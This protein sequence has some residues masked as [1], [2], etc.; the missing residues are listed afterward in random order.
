VQ[1][2]DSG[3]CFKSVR[4]AVQ[5]S[6][7]NEQSQHGN[8]WASSGSKYCNSWNLWQ[9]VLFSKYLHMVVTL[10]IPGIGQYT[11]ERCFR[12]L[13][14][15]NWLGLC[16]TQ[17]TSGK[18]LIQVSTDVNWSAVYNYPVSPT[19]MHPLVSLN[20]A[21]H[22]PRSYK[23]RLHSIYVFGH[24]SDTHTTSHPHEFS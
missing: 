11:L 17:P 24:F 4:V 14:V 15:H 20:D 12:R 10:C 22:P 18:V 2:S 19:S 3:T 16:Y 21:Y 7:H 13:P 6:Q 1:S 5:T 9:C 8:E 23:D